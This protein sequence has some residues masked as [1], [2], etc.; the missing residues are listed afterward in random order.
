MAKEDQDIQSFFQVAQDRDFA[1]D[2]QFRVFDIA[3][4]GASIVNPDDLV[5]AQT[6]ILPTRTIANQPV[7]FMG[8]SFN[9]PGAAQYDGSPS[10]AIQFR[11]DGEHVIRT[12]FEDW[13]REI[14]DDKTSTGAYR[15]FADSTIT[16]HLLN[17]QHKKQ[18]VYKLIGVY[19]VTVGELTYDRAGT[20]APITFT[21]TIAYQYWE[22]EG[23]A[24]AEAPPVA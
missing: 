10:Y 6:A 20:G 1:R 18:K 11:A 16:L 21:A 12:L 2:F 15:M 8:L 9:V 22:R 24:G 17:Q 3:N 14:F 5:Y 13:S 4:R 23:A 7:P 19:P